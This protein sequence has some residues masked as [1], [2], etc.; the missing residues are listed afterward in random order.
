[1]GWRTERGTD[2]VR[3]GCDSRLVGSVYS[4]FGKPECVRAFGCP[5]RY[6]TQCSCLRWTCFTLPSTVQSTHRIH[7]TLPLQSIS[8]PLHHDQHP[9]LVPRPPP[10][11]PSRNALYTYQKSPTSTLPS[12]PETQSSKDYRTNRALNPANASGL[13]LPLC[14]PPTST[15][16]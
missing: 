2:D 8:L 15:L 12:P 4:A 14:Q 3:L 9:H 6:Q 1:M 16:S 10:N 5:I 11:F 7:H 13:C